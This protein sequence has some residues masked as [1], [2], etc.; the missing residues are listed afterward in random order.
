MGEKKYIIICCTWQSGWGVNPDQDAVDDIE[1]IFKRR[2]LNQNA[3]KD[4][5]PLHIAVAKG[6]CLELPPA[7]LQDQLGL[8]LT[9]SLGYGDLD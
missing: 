1:E 4:Q 5:T 8:G 9:F 7:Q 3:L 2:R 6:K